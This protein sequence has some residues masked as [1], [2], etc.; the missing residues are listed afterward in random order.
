MATR[1]G[2]EERKLTSIQCAEKMIQAANYADVTLLDSTAN[3]FASGKYAE[4]DIINAHAEAKKS[5]GLVEKRD[6]ELN[7]EQMNL[8]AEISSTGRKF[9]SGAHGKRIMNNCIPKARRGTSSRN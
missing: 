1:D 5:E 8:L 9:I 2:E 4:R 6:H 7:V 3:L